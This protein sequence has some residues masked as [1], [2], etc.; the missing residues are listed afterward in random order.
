MEKTIEA[1]IVCWSSIGI[2][3]KKMETIIVCGVILG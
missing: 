2:T 1:T 3:E